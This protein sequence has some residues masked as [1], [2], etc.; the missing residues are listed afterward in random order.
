VSDD[1]D[2][3]INHFKADYKYG[4]KKKDRAWGKKKADESLFLCP[5]CE[6]VWEYVRLSKKDNYYE[7]FPTLGKQRKEC[8]KCKN[9]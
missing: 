9:Q 7:D 6:M 3:I 5:S 8:K 1:T 2:W 4:A